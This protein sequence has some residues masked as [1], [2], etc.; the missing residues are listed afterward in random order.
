MSPFASAGTL[1]FCDYSP[2][3]PVLSTSGFGDS[4]PRHR[5]SR[6]VHPPPDERAPTIDGNSSRMTKKRFSLIG[7]FTRSYA[8]LEMSIARWFIGTAA[9]VRR[10]QVQRM[11]RTE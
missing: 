6:A 11:L 4:R 8:V 1:T 10:S 2:W 7:L 3:L 5:E 9:S